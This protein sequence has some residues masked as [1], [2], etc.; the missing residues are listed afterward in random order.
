MS[1]FLALEVIIKAHGIFCSS[2]NSS[3]KCRRFF[4]FLYSSGSLKQTDAET[5]PELPQPTP[6]SPLTVVHTHDAH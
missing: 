3:N 6:K 5:G 4:L 1:S 2:F